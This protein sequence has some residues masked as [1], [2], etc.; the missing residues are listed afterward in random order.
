MLEIILQ[1]FLSAGEVIL[2]AHWID[3]SCE[4]IAECS[5]LGRFFIGSLLLAASTSAPE[6]FVDLKATAQGLPNLAAGDLLGSS[7]INL[8][9]F[10]VLSLKYKSH[11]TESLSPAAISLSI[12]GLVLTVQIGFY[13]LFPSLG[14]FAGLH[15]GSYLLLGTYLVGMWRSFASSRTNNFSAKPHQESC[16][17]NMSYR[18]VLAFVSATLLLFF[19]ASLLISSMELIA[20]RTGLG[21]TFLGSTLLA[22]TTSFPELVASLIAMRMGAFS[23]MAGNILGSNAFNM[24]IFIGMDFVWTQGSLWEQ[25]SKSHL[26]TAFLVI[27]NTSILI[28]SWYPRSRENQRLKRNS[29]LW[30]LILTLLGFGLIFYF[31]S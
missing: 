28:F 6:F 7:L 23:L 3:K 5:G 10:S 2:A 8:M 19:A 25:I 20:L 13:I 16:R 1:F 15:W 31:N 4:E 27:F 29:N 11:Q 14:H 21:S 9:I 24:M 12:M 18:T 22:F 30:I 17:K 26:L